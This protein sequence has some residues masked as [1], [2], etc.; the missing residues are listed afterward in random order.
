MNCAKHRADPPDPVEG[1]VVLKYLLI[2]VSYKLLYQA[3][4]DSYIEVYLLE[5]IAG[6]RARAGFMTP[7]AAMKPA[8]V[9]VNTVTPIISVATGNSHFEFPITMHV[10]NARKNETCISLTKTWPTCSLPS[11]VRSTTPTTLPC[12]ALAYEYIK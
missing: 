1:K 5:R 10:A 9:P 11:P 4:Y 6:A 7:A 12:P 8:R 2:T 3:I